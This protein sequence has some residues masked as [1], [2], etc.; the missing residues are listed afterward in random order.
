MNR[1]SN[2][3]KKIETYVS[4]LAEETDKFKKS[5][6]FKEYLDT[7]VKFWVYSYR[8]QL[9]IHVQNPFASRVA[10]FRKWNELG[11]TVVKGSKAIKILAPSTKKIVKKEPNG[12]EKEISLTYFF[13]VNVF[14]ITQTHGKK[15]P[16]IDLN[17][18]GDTEKDLLDRFLGFCKFK[19]IR[20]EFKELGVNGLYGYSKGGKIVVWAN[21]TVNTKVNTLIHEIAHELAHYSE[22]GKK[23]SKTEKEI[24]AEATVYV[25]SKILGFESKSPNYLSLFPT[26]KK[27]ILENFETISNT[28]KTI[29]EFETQKEMAVA[30]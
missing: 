22:E 9:L 19:N 29:L 4:K 13:P 25:I 20:V 3:D 27:R 21:Q 14:D 17:V 6:F 2:L 26:D 24:Q 8:N 18:K 10:G 1:L 30:K 15:L 11:R 23:F 5:A 16:D 12:E 28:V 7:M